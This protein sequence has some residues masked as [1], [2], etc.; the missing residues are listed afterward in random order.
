MDNLQK[1]PEGFRASRRGYRVLCLD[2]GGIRGLVLCQVLRAI[3]R[4]AGRPIRDLYDWIIG[5]LILVF[6][7]E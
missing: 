2:G 3:E 7:T 5:E 6:I 1:D 4:A